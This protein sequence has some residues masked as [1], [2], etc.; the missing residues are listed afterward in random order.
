[1]LLTDYLVS[2]LGSVKSCKG[3]GNNVLRLD[4]VDKV[5]GN[6]KFVADLCP[7]FTLT[8]KILGNCLCPCQST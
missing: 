1:M 8:G 4:G 5:T 2:E 3:K 7:G 6:A